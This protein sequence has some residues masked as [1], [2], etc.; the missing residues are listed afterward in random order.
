M[1]TLGH[2][3]TLRLTLLRN[4]KLFPKMTTGIELDS[5]QMPSSSCSFVGSTK[6]REIC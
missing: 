4:C 1:E 3:E 2:M 6:N 5:D